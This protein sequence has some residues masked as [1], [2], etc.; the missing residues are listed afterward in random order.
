MAGRSTAA[1]VATFLVNCVQVRHGLARAA[2]SQTK[3]EASAA[4]AAAG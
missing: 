4:A 2:P 3:P 1:I